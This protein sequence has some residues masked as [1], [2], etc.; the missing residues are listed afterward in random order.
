MGTLFFL[1]ATVWLS[2]STGESTTGRW[3]RV[4]Q[5]ITSLRQASDCRGR[6]DGWDF[7]CRSGYPG[8]PCRDQGVRRR[9]VYSSEITARSFLQEKVLKIGAPNENRAPRPLR[10][11]Q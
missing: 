6:I 5:P 7:P 4:T 10:P 3:K 9:A 8:L 1:H 11:W 2:V